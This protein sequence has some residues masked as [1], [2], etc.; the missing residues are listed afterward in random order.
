MRPLNVSMMNNVSL[1]SIKIDRGELKVL[2]LRDDE[3]VWINET[4]AKV[5]YTEI[6]DNSS[7]YL[8]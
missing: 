8:Q 7:E 3:G 6:E 5:T 2:Q 1:N 4:S